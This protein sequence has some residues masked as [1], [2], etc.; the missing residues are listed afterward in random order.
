M[1]LDDFA[2]KL[3]NQASFLFWDEIEQ[4]LSSTKTPVLAENSHPFDDRLSR[5]NH[6]KGLSVLNLCSSSGRDFLANTGLSTSW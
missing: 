5:N 2:Q 1:K 3:A 6:P 4:P